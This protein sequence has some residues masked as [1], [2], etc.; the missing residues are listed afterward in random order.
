MA[1]RSSLVAM[2]AASRGD[3]ARRR[4][5]PRP[6]RNGPATGATTGARRRSP[7]RRSGVCRWRPRASASTSQCRRF[8]D[9]TNV[10]NPLF[11]VSRQES[12]LLLG[13]VD[14]Q[15]F[16]T[17]VTLLP[18][19]RIIAWQGQAGRDARLPVRRLP[20]RAHPRGG[21]RLLRPGRRRCGVVLRRGRLQLQGWAH[22]RHPRHLDRRQGRPGGDDHA[23]RPPGRRRLPAREHPGLRVRGGHRQGRRPAPSTGRSVR[24]RA[25]SRSRSST[26]TGRRRRRPSGPATAS[27]SP[28]AAVTWRRSPWRCRPTRS[29][30]PTPAELLTLESAAAD[31]FAA[32]GAEDWDSARA[33]AEE[34]AA[35]WENVQAGE[36]PDRLGPQLSRALEALANG[37]G[38][39]E[40]TS[41][42]ARRRSTSLAGASTCSSVT[43]R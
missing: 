30:G 21:V 2:L 15:P 6:R 10:T 14:G 36:V 42:R 24:S 16:R 20:R 13:R 43:V 17:E 9:P 38:G 26:W 23:R 4:W 33:T 31:A 41:E 40:R 3:P 39:R 5:V 25:G 32:A 34:T 19:T 37:V 12:V 29:S 7:S 35:A 22:R 1:T 18:E 28:R 8:S 11:P 27:S